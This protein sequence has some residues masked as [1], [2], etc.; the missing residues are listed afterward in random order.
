MVVESLLHL[1]YLHIWNYCCCAGTLLGKGC[2]SPL[3]V[4]HWPADALSFRILHLQCNKLFV[5][6]MYV[7]SLPSPP[8]LPSHPSAGGSLHKSLVRLKVTS[9]SY[10]RTLFLLA[11]PAQGSSSGFLS[12]AWRQSLLWQMLYKW[13]WIMWLLAEGYSHD[14]RNSCSFVNRMFSQCDLNDFGGV[15]FKFFLRKFVQH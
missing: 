10:K 1:F 14:I 12:S 8:T 5:C 4:L 2:V 9:C 7:P 13:N 15:V 11:L 6:M 3:L